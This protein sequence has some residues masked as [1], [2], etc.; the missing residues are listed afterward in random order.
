M[1]DVRS[2]HTP[3][4]PPLL[5]SAMKDVFWE[6][7]G[8]RM[9]RN[10]LSCR[11]WDYVVCLIPGHKFTWPLM[12]GVQ[13][14]FYFSGNLLEF[15][16]YR[17]LLQAGW[18][19]FLSF[20]FVCVKNVEYFN[21]Y[22]YRNWCGLVLSDSRNLSPDRYDGGFTLTCTVEREPVPPPLHGGVLGCRWVAFKPT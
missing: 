1:W 11:L 12:I 16:C 10:G 14:L 18:F 21:Q 4:P 5:L 15:M 13:V 7:M 8:R 17:S 6:M 2:W 3:S 9:K 22:S 19:L 20:A